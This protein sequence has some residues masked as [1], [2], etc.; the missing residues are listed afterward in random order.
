MNSKFRIENVNV[1]GPHAY[2]RASI[3]EGAYISVSSG[4]ELGGVRLRSELHEP[5]QG[6]Y[7]FRLE[8]ASDSH[9]LKVGSIVE[10]VR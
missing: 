4:S 3:V 8:S 5:S 7:L 1:D 6:T 2:V 10:L 9:K